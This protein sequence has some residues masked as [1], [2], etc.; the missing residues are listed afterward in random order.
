VFFS[1]NEVEVKHFFRGFGVVMWGCHKQEKCNKLHVRWIQILGKTLTN[2]N[3][4]HKETVSGLTF[5]KACHRFVQ[6][7]SPSHLLSKNAKIKIY[8][9]I[10]L[11]SVLY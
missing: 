6:N 2:Q 3:R 7:H 8:R 11:P 9:T 5:G 10:N 1:N 4:I